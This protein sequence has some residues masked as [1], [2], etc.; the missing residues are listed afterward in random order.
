MKLYLDPGHG[1]T[2]PGASGNGIREKDI[3]LDIA[4][5]IRSILINSYEN[6]EIKMSRTG[7][8]TKSLSQRTNEANAWDADFYLSIHCN[9]ANS[10]ARG[11]EDY[12]YSGVSN[13][14]R[15]A[16][17][18]D[19][20]HAEVIKLNQLINRGQKKANFH[21]LRET[22]MDAF[23][24]E[25]GFI[26][27]P[28]DAALM[29]QNSWRQSVAQGHATGVA[30]AF[31]LK[32]KTTTPPPKPPANPAD[33]PKN[34][35]ATG[36][37]YKVIAGSFKGKENAD[38][39][40]IFLRSKGIE[41]FVVTAS[42][43]GGTWYRVQAGAFASRENANTRVAEIKKSGI[44]DAFLLA[45]NENV[46]TRGTTPVI[47]S[48]ILGPAQISAEQMD[49]FVKKVN[50]NAPELGSYYKSLGEYYG[51]RGDVAFAQAVH[52]T[53]YFRYTGVVERGQNNYAGIG[54]TGPDV[55][56]AT[57]AT[58]KDGVL[59]HLQ[60]LYAY[61]TTQPLPTKYPLV[62]PR[63]NLVKRGSAPTWIGL[64]GKWAVPGD[65][66]GQSILSVYEKMITG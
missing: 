43:S 57:F 32:A 58:P 34:P 41:S 51:I 56:G 64:N 54:A 37:L 38:E 6:I 30:K 49:Q 65:T 15:T 20:I 53:N 4:Q 62:D 17:Y 16:T 66:Y 21:V 36:T 2:D 39:R 31:K 40:V 12:I 55:R 22:K 61:A 46:S 29:K 26:D 33:P 27:N 59:G 10:S 9:A 48:T 35:P 50:P 24:S 8:T 5:K 28:E 52:E 63:F 11:Y 13:S 3:T 42:I 60:H 14:S 18:Q 47:P 7:D 23:L 25:N 19:I 45:E 44:N 1:G